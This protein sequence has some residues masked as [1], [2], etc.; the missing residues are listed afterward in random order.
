MWHIQ[1]HYSIPLFCNAPATP[2]FYFFATCAPLSS[3]NVIAHAAVGPAKQYMPV[4]GCQHC[5]TILHHSLNR[6]L[7]DLPNR[8]LACISSPDMFNYDN[9]AHIAKQQNKER[10]E[11]IEYCEV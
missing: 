10:R 4:D 3:V 7:L 1:P 5:F 8:P 9:E 6:E 11:T 2:L